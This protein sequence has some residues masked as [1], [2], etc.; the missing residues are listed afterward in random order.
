M[1]KWEY[2]EMEVEIGGPLTG[3]KGKARICQ[4]NG[5]HISAGEGE[6]GALMAKLGEV[7]WELAASSARTQT[8]LSANHKINYIFKRPK[9]ESP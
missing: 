7:G 4:A 2:L 6:P 5:K 1:Q 3:Q 9:T 8:G